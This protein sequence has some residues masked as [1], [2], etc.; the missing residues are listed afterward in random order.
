MQ[1]HQ[2][3]TSLNKATI[4]GNN[5]PTALVFAHKRIFPGGSG[6]FGY[7]ES[8]KKAEGH[9]ASVVTSPNDFVINTLCQTFNY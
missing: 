5:C 2:S 8:F 3:L 9:R 1:R 7:A 6:S 4:C